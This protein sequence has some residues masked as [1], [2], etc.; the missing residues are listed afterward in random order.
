MNRHLI[1]LFII[2]MQMKTTVRKHLIL[3]RMATVNQTKP[4]NKCWRDYEITEMQ[5]GVAGGNVSIKW[6]SHGKQ[7]G[8]FSRIRVTILLLFSHLVMST[9]L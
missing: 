1:S 9:S 3:T 4:D 7:F 5:N 2:I 8:S 6:Y